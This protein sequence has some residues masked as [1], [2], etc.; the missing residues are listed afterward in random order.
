MQ[1]MNLSRGHILAYI[2]MFKKCKQGAT[3]NSNV[4]LVVWQ[5]SLSICLNSLDYKS[6]SLFTQL[7][8]HLTHSVVS[9]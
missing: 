8:Q 6:K 7:D 9:F 3:E 2:N 5:G 4:P 1:I